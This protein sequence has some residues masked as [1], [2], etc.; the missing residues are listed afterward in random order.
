MDN[1]KITLETLKGMLKDKQQQIQNEPHCELWQ[2]EATQ[3]TRAIEL[4]EMERTEVR[5]G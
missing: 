4:V 2:D 1:I 3:L 5:N